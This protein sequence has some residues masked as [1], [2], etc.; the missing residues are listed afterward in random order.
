MNCGEANALLDALMDDALTQEQR[1]ALEAHA[2]ACPDCAAAMRATEQ[3][4]ALFNQME[5]EVDVPLKTQAAWRGAVREEAGRRRR[6]RLYRRIASAAAAAVA[7]V[8]IGLAFNLRGTPKDNAAM[9]SEAPS[10]RIV[11][12][13]SGGNADSTA[14]PVMLKAAGEAAEYAAAGSAVVEADGAYESDSDDEAEAFDAAMEA[15]AADS[16]IEMEEATP[17]AVCAAVAQRAPACEFSL[18][19]S[20]VKTACER[21]ADL[22]QEY[23]GTA[24]V[25]TLA[26][27]G[28]N[29]YVDIDG[30]DAGDF[31]SAVAAM[32]ASGQALEVPEVAPEGRA[33]V[34][35]TIEK[36]ED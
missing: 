18:R 23:E 3:M 9:L 27:G 26:D 12:A 1:S 11:A 2:Q 17:N 25:Q 29:V 13:E 24:D 16:F 35:L 33:L 34:L 8:G 15:P 21:I 7:L 36:Q 4:K 5:P 6:A 14:M 20:D 30:G 22:V 19:V 10:E 31:L 28:A 32:D